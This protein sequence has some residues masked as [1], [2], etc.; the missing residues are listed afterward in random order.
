MSSND[1]LHRTFTDSASSWSKEAIFACATLIVMAFFST[2]GLFCKYRAASWMFARKS[3]LN[4]FQREEQL[5]QVHRRSSWVEL[6]VV[7]KSQQRTYT[8]EIRKIR[9]PK[10]ARRGV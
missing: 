10:I 7:R 9:G 8:S 4:P 6:E 2:L 3:W 1:T 5:L